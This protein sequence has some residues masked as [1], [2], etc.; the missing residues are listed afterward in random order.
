MVCVNRF[1]IA[2]NTQ[3]KSDHNTK[4]ESKT[5]L[6]IFSQSVATR[7]AEVDCK[8]WLWKKVRNSCVLRN[9]QFFRIPQY[10]IRFRGGAADGNIFSGDKY[11][12][13]RLLLNSPETDY[14]VKLAFRKNNV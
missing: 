8:S 1:G 9:R 4:R 6:A 11:N 12:L 14:I 3:A 10:S 5:P 7:T 2:G 13:M